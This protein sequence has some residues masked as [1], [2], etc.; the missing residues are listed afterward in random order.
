MFLARQ[1]IDTWLPDFIRKFKQKSQQISQ[2]YNATKCI[3][4]YCD[5][6]VN[7]I[8]GWTLFACIKKQQNTT[9]T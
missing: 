3:N 9:K 5:D 7:Q 4:T 8:V 6:E 2:K 1:M